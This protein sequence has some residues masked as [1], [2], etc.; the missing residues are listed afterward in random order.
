MVTKELAEARVRE[1]RAEA[2]RAGRT[3]H[4]PVRAAVRRMRARAAR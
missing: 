1:L 3:Q 4:H 2:A